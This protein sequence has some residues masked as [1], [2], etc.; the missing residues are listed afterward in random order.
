[1]GSGDSD[2]AVVAVDF[3]AS[4]IRV[5]RVDLGRRPPALE[6]VHRYHHQPIADAAGHLRWD[7]ARL[8]AEMDEGLARA[9]EQGPVASI[10]VDTWGVDYGL[11][12]HRGDLVA[13]PFSYRDTRTDGWS[14][15]VERIGA[16]ALY[17]GTGL[18]LQPFNTIFQVAAHDPDELAR[19]RHLLLLPE[20]VVHHLT[21]ELVAEPTSAGTTGLVDIHSG[22]WSAGLAE[23][24]GLDPGLLAPITPAGSCVGRWH[25]IPVHLVG[26]HDTASAVV[27]MGA[28]P[29]RTSAFVSSGTWLLVGWELPAPDLSDAARQ[30]NFTNE[31]G[32]QGNVRF[33]KNLAGW[34]LLDGCRAAW[35]PEGSVDGL[36]DAAAQLPPGP[37]VDVADPRFLHPDDMLTEVT[38]AAGRPRDCPPAVVARVIV[39]SMAEGMA[40]VIGQLAAVTGEAVSD[41]YVFG[42]GS[43]SALHRRTLA[44]RTGLVVRAGP[45]EATALGNALVQGIALGVYADLDAARASLDAEEDSA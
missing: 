10:G 8:V 14:E 16:D 27:A 7:W 25:G 22:E 15:V 4:S 9:R 23:A 44:E 30:A 35:G 29:G 43:R 45:V 20:L 42:G 37:V 6:V 36:L 13:P 38:A 26:G 41:V 31:R 21:G 12:D 11:L 33:L 39:D 2:V 3:G 24:V 18:Q 34:W 5:C 40:R 1:V 19:A 32:V 28:A 17:A